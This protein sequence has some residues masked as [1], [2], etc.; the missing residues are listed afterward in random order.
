[1]EQVKTILCAVDLS[2]LSERVTKYAIMMAKSFNAELIV[3]YASPP[4]NQYAALEVQP[5]ALEIFGEEI[6]AGAEKQMDKLMSSQFAGIKAAARIA[7]GNP[8]EEILR[9]AK[10]SNADLII[11]GTHGRKGVELIL[12][13]SVAEKVVKGSKIPVLTVQP[14]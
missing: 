4:L 2:D 13:G 8:A 12:F 14:S 5:K 10:E 9:A 11:M 7:S 3:L 1:M 6:S